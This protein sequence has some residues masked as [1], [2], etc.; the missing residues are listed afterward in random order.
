M[1]LWI[2]MDRVLDHYKW[3]PRSHPQI[4]HGLTWQLLETF[5]DLVAPRLHR[6]LVFTHDE[7]KEHQ[8]DKLTSV[9]LGHNNNIVIILTKTHLR[10]L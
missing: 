2:T 10:E 8:G 6:D 1:V 4:T 7:G 5:E 3:S 9:R